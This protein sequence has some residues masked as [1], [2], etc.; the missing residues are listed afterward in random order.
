MKIPDYFRV[1]GQ[2]LEVKFPQSIEGDKLGKCCLAEGIIK[3]A[4]T[5]NGI[6]QSESSQQ[7]TFFHEL[8]H[9]ILDTMGRGD[10][11]GDEPFVNTF[12]SFLNEAYYSSGYYEKGTD[13]EKG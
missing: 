13:K 11:S 1:G 9:S 3:I 5:F 6:E 8:V 2:L 7:N 12:A 10:L 4:K